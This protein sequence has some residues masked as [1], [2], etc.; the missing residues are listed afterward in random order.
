MRKDCNYK[1]ICKKNTN[2]Q[3]LHI[4]VSYRGVGKLI[5]LIIFSPHIVFYHE[6]F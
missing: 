1:F 6:F 5:N 2:A 3:K 4:S